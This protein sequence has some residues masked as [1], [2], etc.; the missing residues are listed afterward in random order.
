MVCGCVHV[1]RM[2]KNIV[3]IT[4]ISTEE[5]E[6]ERETEEPNKSA[7][8]VHLQFSI[9]QTLYAMLFILLKIVH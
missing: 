6:R 3:E 5:R 8:K 7:A 4:N 2:L 1:E 9:V